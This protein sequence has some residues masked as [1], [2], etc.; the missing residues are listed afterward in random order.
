MKENKTWIIVAIMGLALA[1]SII[2]S[3]ILNHKINNIEPEKIVTS[4]SIVQA[5]VSRVSIENTLT[6]NGKIIRDESNNVSEIIDEQGNVVGKITNEKEAK[7]NITIE[8]NDKEK[9]KDNLEIVINEKDSDKKYNGIINK[10][11]EVSENTFNMTVTFE[12]N[13]LLENDKIVECKVTLEKAEDVI[14]VP[15]EAVQTNNQNQKYVIVINE[16]GTTTETIVETG[17]SDPFYIEI[18][19]GLNGGEKIQLTTSTT[20]TSNKNQNQTK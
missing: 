2:Y 5:R 17:I 3:I 14:A 7:I 13:M 19:N 16:D 6:G 8:K 18:T 9:L 4:T 1:I 10:V 12:E 11:E 20:V 15:V